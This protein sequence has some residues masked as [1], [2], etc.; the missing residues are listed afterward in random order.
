MAPRRNGKKYFVRIE[1]TLRRPPIPARERGFSL[2][3]VM[4]ATLILTLGV[5]GLYGAY[6]FGFATIKIAQEDLG[7]DRI[8]VQRLETLRVYDWSRITNNYIPTN[9]TASLGTNGGIVYQ[10]EMAIDPAPLT[11]SYSNTLRQVTV[12]SSWDSGG[13]TRH[14]SMTTLV[15]QNGIQTYKP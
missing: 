3:E 15:S 14:R 11:E 1:A 9:L 6:S 10:V 13:V 5:V 2:V 7:A 12:S 4:I 8:M